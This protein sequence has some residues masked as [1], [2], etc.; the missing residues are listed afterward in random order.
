MPELHTRLLADVIALGSPYPLVLTGGYAV[1]AHRLVNR[2]SQDPDVAT[3]NPAPM[4]DIA[5]AL[6]SGLTARGDGLLS[7]AV[8][9][10]PYGAVRVLGCAVEDEV[11]VAWHLLLRIER[12]GDDIDFTDCVLSPSGGH[13]PGCA[14]VGYSNVAVH[15]TSALAGDVNA[16]AA[17]DDEERKEK[18]LEALRRKP[19]LRPLPAADLGGSLRATPWG[20]LHTFARA[21]SLARRGAARSLAEHWGSLKYNL[22]LNGSPSSYMGLSAEG[23]DTA[24]LYKALQS[25][26]LGVGFAPALS[27]RILSRRY[28]DHA[29]PIVPADTALRA[30]PEQQGQGH[31][32]GLPVPSAVLRRGLE[33][34]RTVAHLPSRLPRQPR[35]GERLPRPTRGRS[36]LVGTVY[37]M[38]FAHMPE[39]HWTFG[40]PFAITLMG[41]VCVGLY[42][43]F[44]RRDWL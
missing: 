35:Q 42:L 43:I 22:A 16:A 3:E 24:D 37:G 23:R 26:E 5:A 13:R 34:R 36:G 44:K 7:R 30:G 9:G 8:H 39:L 32:G 28:P 12:E 38:N 20:V 4:A 31:H 25:G 29:V 21:N 6:C 33:A 41:A 11:L 10:K 17:A 40:Y 19:D 2:P 27:E 14:G 1:R 18:D 15:S